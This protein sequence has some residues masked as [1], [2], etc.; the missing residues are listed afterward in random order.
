MSFSLE[1]DAYGAK[2]IERSIATVSLADGSQ[3]DH[4]S[5]IKFDL[6]LD[7]LPYEAIN[8][9]F[10]V[11][12]QFRIKDMKTNGTFYTDSNGLMMQKRVKDFRPSWDLTY[13]DPYQR[14]NITANY[15]PVN[16]AIYIED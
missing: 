4:L 10:E 3:K 13:D 16:S 5:T 9:G 2:S 1:K 7:S 14:E 15:Y 12:T 11:V 6:I 8:D